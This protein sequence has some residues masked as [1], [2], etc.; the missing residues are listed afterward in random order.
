MHL[1]YLRK[2]SYEQIV[3]EIHKT[4]GEIIPERKETV[5]CHALYRGTDVTGWRGRD[6]YPVPR[7]KGVKLYTCKTLKK[8]MAE[9]ESLHDYCGEWFDI[10][11]ENGKVDITK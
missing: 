3:P 7:N 1:Y 5:E 4:N 6:T 8:I 9:R 11:D 2:E 10:Y